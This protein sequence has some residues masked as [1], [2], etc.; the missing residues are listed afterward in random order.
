[1]VAQGDVY[2]AELSPP[3]GS[4]PGFSRPVVIVQNDRFNQSRL[5]TVVAVILT[6]QLGRAGYPGNVILRPASTGLPRDS[7]AN[8]TQIVTIDRSR[9]LEQV[10]RLGARELDQVL[11]G[12]VSLLGR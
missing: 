5:N 4:E 7:V 9:L 3:A 8:V 11:D 1:V 12:V 2:W 10:G 6:G